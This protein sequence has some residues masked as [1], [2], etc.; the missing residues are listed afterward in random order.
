MLYLYCGDGTAD[1]EKFIFENIDPHRKT[2]LIVP[3]QF[4]L[5]AERDAFRLMKRE[6]LMDM[7]VVDFS[8]LGHKVINEVD[9]HEPEIIDKYGRHMLLTVLMDEIADE[10]VTYGSLR[11]RNSF[12][13]HMNTMISELKRYEIGVEELRAVR[14]EIAEGQGEKGSYLGMKLDD[15]LTIYSAY[16]KAIEGIYQDA[17]DHI[18]Y[19]SERIPESN[20]VRDADIWIYG[21]DTFTPKHLTVIK[22]LIRTAAKVCVVL[23]DRND[24]TQTDHVQRLT[25]NE[26]EGL[27][28]LTRLV[29]GRLEEAAK[30]AGSSF[31]K[32]WIDNKRAGIWDV[33]DEERKERIELFE[34]SDHHHEAE[35]AAAYIKHL[36]RDEG[37]R[38][39]EITVICN[40]TEGLGGMLARSLQRMD[41][42]LFTDRKRQVL[43]QPVVSFLLS[44]LDVIDRGY[45]NESVMGMIKSGLLGWSAE[46]EALLEN[47]VR[48]FRIRSGMWKK[49]FE[50]KADQYSDEELK[51]VNRMRGSLMETCE[52]ARDSIGRRNTAEEKVNGLYGFLR[53]D[54]NIP[55]KIE[56]MIARQSEMSLMEGASETAQIWNAICGIFEQ[57]IRV[58]GER[59]ISNSTLAEMVRAGLTSLE[60]G[61]VPASGDSLIMGTLQRT[62]PGRVRAL[63][64]VGAEEG[65]LPLHNNEEGLLTRRELEV[66]ENM[67]LE[68]ARKKTIAGQ[69]EQMAIYRI[70]SLPE[71]KLYVSYSRTGAEGRAAQASSVFKKLAEHQPRIGGDLE[72][73]DM[74]ESVLGRGGTI[75]YLAE[76]IRRRKRREAVDPRWQEVARWY[77]EEDPQLLEKIENGSGYSIRREKLTEDMARALFVGDRDMLMA[78]ASRLEKF[79]GCPFAHFIMYGLKPREERLFEVGGREIGDIYHE[80]IMKYCEEVT[81][82]SD[83]PDVHGWDEITR[84]ECDEKIR[85]IIEENEGAYRGGVF[86]SDEDGRFRIQR[87][88]EICC[89]IAWAITWQIRKG[90]ISSMR[91][92]EPFGVGGRLP[93]T[94]IDVDGKKVRITGKIDRMDT[95]GPIQVSDGSSVRIIDYKTGSNEIDP[96][97]IRE[98]YQLQLAMYMDAASREE[99]VEPAGIFYFK[100]KE[101]IKDENGGEDPDPDEIRRQIQK[102]YRLEGIAVNDEKVLREMDGSLVPGD[103]YESLVVPVKYDP[104]KETF[105][106][107]SGGE[108]MEKEEFSNLLKESRKQVEDICRRLYEGQIG[109]VPHKSKKKVF[110]R[111]STACDYCSF[112]S[113]CMFDRSFPECKYR[114]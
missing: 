18:T 6:S 26:G 8:A 57:I 51:Q 25:M 14:E 80:S 85:R 46:E 49:P 100:I 12:T 20:I 17:E 99:D 61:L 101:F 31:E 111:E 63:V 109:P 110:G 91:F 60:I 2:I 114:D 89:D 75:S 71:E 5:Q 93:A 38:Y 50:Y 45:R 3:D 112:G 29:I 97:E 87:V 44:F 106:S 90:Q 16:E 22:S 4:S 64:V 27:F 58:I 96:E 54:F 92:E 78:S 67:D 28:D 98:G 66:L 53:D 30:E 13:E 36:V 65:V 40:D 33:S 24:R 23:T 39:N 105:L 70:F 107:T 108:L 1:K 86:D 48:E 103:K 32:L 79:S 82:Q 62:R 19:Y 11:G 52:K 77:R 95:M 21:F 37:Y 42:P 74:M 104:R 43:H 72:G 69:E 59:K 7:M 41:I 94:E 88:T 68:L 84:E 102:S 34:T 55:E 81:A 10:L 83:R 56:E 9:G 76:T 113:I 15:I 47:Y 35:R 73:C